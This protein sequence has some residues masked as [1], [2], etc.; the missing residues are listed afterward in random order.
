[1]LYCSISG[2]WK[3]NKKSVKIKIYC[4]AY[5]QTVLFIARKRRDIINKKNNAYLTDS[6]KMPDKLPGDIHERELCMMIGLAYG[7]LS[8]ECFL[9]CF[10]MFTNEIFCSVLK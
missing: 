2:L 1:M 10:L 5:S 7:I 3:E 4:S 8:R 6:I 9:H